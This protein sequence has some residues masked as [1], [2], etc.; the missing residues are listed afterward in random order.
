MPLFYLLY[1]TSG[2]FQ[3]QKIG[4]ACC[5]AKGSVILSKYVLHT[6]LVKAGVERIEI[7]GI[8]IILSYSQ[9]IAK[10]LIMHYLTLTQ[11]LN[12]LFYV[13]VVNKSEY[14]VV[15]CARLLLWH[16]AVKTTFFQNFQWIF[17]PISFVH[18][19][20]LEIS[21]LSMSASVISLVRCSGW[22]YFS[23]IFLWSL[24]DSMRAFVC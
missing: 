7:L 23:M 4:R 10:S 9:G 20:F 14:V 3:I 21:I 19:G 13:R 17:M 12:R 11:E 6:A 24:P 8:E 5:S 22:T 1:C 16:Y 15:R 2:H 18:K